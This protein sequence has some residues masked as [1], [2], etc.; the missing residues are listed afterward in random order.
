MFSLQRSKASK[1]RPVGRRSHCK[2]CISDKTKE[3]NSTPRGRKYNQEKAWRVKG[4]VL[5]VEEYQEML[6]NQNWLCAI[7]GADRNKDGTRLCVDHNHETGKI[8]GLLCH[9]CNTSL[10]KFKDSVELLQKAIDYLNM[11]KEEAL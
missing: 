6:E 2:Q 11:Y 1:N 9:G 5:T 10:G 7:C 3:Y 8:R 4:I